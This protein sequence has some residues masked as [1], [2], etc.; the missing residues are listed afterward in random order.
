M[1]DLKKVQELPEFK[2]YEEAVDIFGSLLGQ[3]VEN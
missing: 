3:Q 2:K 1:E